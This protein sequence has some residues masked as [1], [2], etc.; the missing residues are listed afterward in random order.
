MQ[1]QE[2]QKMAEYAREAMIRTGFDIQIKVTPVCIAVQVT[3]HKNHRW[4]RSVLWVNIVE[5]D[6]A[7]YL[8]GNVDQ[9]VHEFETQLRAIANNDR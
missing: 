8:T 3:D 9:A 7:A 6:D 1:I 4:N 5:F 2:I